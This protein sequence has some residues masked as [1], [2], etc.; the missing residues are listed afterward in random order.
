[1]IWLLIAPAVA[2]GLALALRHLPAETR[3]DIP[4]AAITGEDR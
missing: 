2:A 3:T 4:S 1:M